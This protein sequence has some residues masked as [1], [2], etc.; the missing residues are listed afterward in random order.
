VGVYDRS[1]AHVRCL[2]AG[3]SIVVGAMVICDVEDML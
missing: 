2:M 1:D 3:R